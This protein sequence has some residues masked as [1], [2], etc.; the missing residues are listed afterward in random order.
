MARSRSGFATHC[1]LIL[2][3]LKSSMARAAMTQ[4]NDSSCAQA[5]PLAT[6]RLAALDRVRVAWLFPSLEYGGYWHPVFQAFSQIFP[7]TKIYTGCWDGFVRGF[8]NTFCVEVVGA[9]KTIPLS[10]K[11]DGY[12]PNIGCPS[13]DI[14]RRLWQFRPQIIFTSSF[15]L[16]TLVAVLMQPLM[17]WKI[18]ILYDGWS[19]TYDYRT[20]WIR[21]LLRRWL[22]NRADRVLTNSLSGQEYL[23]NVLR[24]HP[25]RVYLQPYQVPNLRALGDFHEL[26]PGPERSAAPAGPRFLFIG[27]LVP[28]KGL[29]FLL[30]ACAI[31]QARGYQQFSLVIVG[32]GDAR[33]DLEAQGQQLGLHNLVWEGRVAY[34]QMGQY[35]AQTDVFVFPTLEDIWGMVL[36]EAMA[37]GK[38]VLCSRWAGAAEMMVVEGQNGFQFDPRDPESLATLMQKFLDQP[39]LI[40]VMGAA[41]HDML[42]KYTP[43]SAT[44]AFT[45][46]TR[47]VM[48]A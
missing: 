15:S 41:A 23:V 34:D 1:A 40:P 25:D 27:R 24:G 29:N 31:L 43:E 14:V 33:A 46:L 30:E 42:A 7:Q 18:V 44:A 22:L 26:L 5:Q 21:L 19:P 38:P 13:P 20:S 35:F 6:D 2:K 9:T 4:S 10:F 39:E 8:E 47:S 17:A 12:I 37:C 28:R 3:F 11:R 36:L 45:H 16:W 32:E 48:L